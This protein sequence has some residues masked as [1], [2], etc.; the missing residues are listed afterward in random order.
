ML[1]ILNA[2]DQIIHITN[3]N[4]ILQIHTIFYIMYNLQLYN[5]CDFI[6]EEIFQIILVIWAT[7][8]L[9]YKEF[10]KFTVANNQNFIPSPS[11]HQT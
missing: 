6:D 9:L 1:I 11:N 8:H 4:Y 5:Y 10:T 7:L 3:N 2:S